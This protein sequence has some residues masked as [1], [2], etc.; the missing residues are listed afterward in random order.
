MRE[1]WRRIGGEGRKWTEV[2]LSRWKGCWRVSSLSSSLCLSFLPS[3]FWM[4]SD[5]T[6]HILWG[7][8]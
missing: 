1:R 3:H 7:L 5:L 4:R 6:C 8:V 2:W